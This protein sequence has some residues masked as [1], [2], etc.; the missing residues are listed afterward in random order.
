MATTV[1]EECVLQHVRVLSLKGLRKKPTYSFKQLAIPVLCKPNNG[2]VGWYT[3]KC[4]FI[5]IVDGMKHHGAQYLQLEGGVIKLEAIQLMFFAEFLETHTMID[6]DNASH[7]ECLERLVRFL[8][9]IQLHFFVGRNI[10]GV[11]Y[12]TPDPAVVFGSGRCI[13]RILNKGAHFEFI[14]THENA[15]I[16]HVSEIPECVIVNEQN[17]IYMKSVRS[18]TDHAIALALSDQ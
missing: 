7:K 5:S 12:T 3:N 11:W 10:D 1:S 9:A 13:I 8:P 18:E 2:V 16:N 6:T 4:C 14:T 17:D 15:F